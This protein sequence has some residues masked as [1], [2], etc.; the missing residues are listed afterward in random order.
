M[1]NPKVVTLAPGRV[2]GSGPQEQGYGRMPRFRGPGPGMI[3]GVVM[4]GAAEQIAVVSVRRKQRRY[5]GCR[6]GSGAG[7]DDAKGAGTDRTGRG[8]RRP[9]ASA[10]TG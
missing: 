2:R 8:S 6:G 5:D 10:R 9:R 7:G 1:M 3:S 4:S